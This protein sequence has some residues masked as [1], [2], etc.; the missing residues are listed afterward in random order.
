MFD[1]ASA[2]NQPLGSF[3]TSKVTSFQAGFRYARS[4]NQPVPF[5]T[6]NATVMAEMFQGAVAFNQTL[7][8]FD[9]SKIQ[10]METMFKHAKSLIKMCYLLV[11]DMSGMFAGAS[12][13]S[14]NLT[15]W[16]W[17][18]NKVTKV[19]DMFNG[20]ACPNQTDPLLGASPQGPFCYPVSA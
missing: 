12:S 7:A 3:D 16:S 8:S 14:R 13:F 1:E 15:A 18:V 20:T 10:F 9:T 17:T 5:D 4:F 6:A 19:T 11:L 2:F